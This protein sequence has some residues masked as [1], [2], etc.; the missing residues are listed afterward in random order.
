[1]DKNT[2]AC[3]IPHGRTIWPLEIDQ[4]KRDVSKAAEGGEINTSAIRFT[5]GL[6]MYVM[7]IVKQVCLRL[8]L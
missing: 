2:G 7:R 5:R 4:L 6:L 8:V 3:I 1:M